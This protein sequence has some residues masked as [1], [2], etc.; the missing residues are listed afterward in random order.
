PSPHARDLLSF[1]TRRSS[2]LLRRGPEVGPEA[3]GDAQAQSVSRGEPVGCGQQREIDGDWPA[4]GERLGVFM[5]QMVGEVE[6]S[7]RDQP[8]D[9][10]STRLNSSHVSMSYAV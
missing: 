10:K 2:D 4:R 8:G 5:A 6:Q 1:P 3:R 9:R 7:D